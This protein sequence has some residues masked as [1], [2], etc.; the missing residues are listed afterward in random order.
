MPPPLSL[1]VIEYLLTNAAFLTGDQLAGLVA[2]SVTSV[3]EAVRAVPLVVMRPALLREVPR[4]D[5][6]YGRNLTS[7]SDFLRVSGAF[8]LLNLIGTDE[9]RGLSWPVHKALL[10]M[11]PERSSL[12]VPEIVHR[13]AALAAD[14][15]R[16]GLTAA[17][18]NA[19][20]YDLIQGAQSR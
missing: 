9:E 6:L 18:V 16:A 13:Y 8:A 4:L 14:S 20:T 7:L 2:A 3:T 17:L 11:N 12:V 1:T 5:P 15:R 10:R 19:L